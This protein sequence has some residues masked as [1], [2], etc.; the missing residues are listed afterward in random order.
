MSL[1]TE[2]IRTRPDFPWLD[3]AEPEALRRFLVARRFLGADEPIVS[4]GRAGA[5]NMN[6]TLRVATAERSLI[7]KQARPWVERYD[8]IAAPSERADF[9]RRFYARVS[10]IAP[11]AAKMPRLLG[12]DG[13]ASVLVLEDLGSANDCTGAYA[14]EAI[15]PHELDALADYLRSLHDETRGVPDP[16]FANRAM[17]ALNHAHIFE[18]P[19]NPENGV[20]LERHEPGLAAVAARLRR[21][22]TH[23]ALVAATGRRYL[24]DGPCLLH[25]D[26]FPGSWLRTTGGLRVIDPEF[27]FYG[28]PEVDVACAV[29]HLLLADAGAGAVARFVARYQHRGDAVAGGAAHH[30]LIPSLLARYAAVEVLRR[31]AGVAQLPIAPSSGRRAMLLERARAA[32]VDGSLEPL[33]A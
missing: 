6:L 17:R 4:C 15:A 8:H 18:V 22:R 14:G 2:L 20:D 23:A 12:W 24:E 26:Y 10:T 5:G 19:L 13:A 32:M 27:C 3:P 29:A 33:L 21:D 31:I 30:A 16:A 1:R 28:D 7:V 25:G 11:V 9:E